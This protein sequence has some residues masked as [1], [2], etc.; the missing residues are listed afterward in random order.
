M[1]NVAD[2]RTFAHSI[3]YIYIYIYKVNS[4]CHIF[5]KNIKIFF[6]PVEKQA[7]TD[8]N[9]SYTARVTL[10]LFILLS[11]N[12]FLCQIRIKIYKNGIIRKNIYKNATQMQHKNL[13]CIYVFYMIRYHKSNGGGESK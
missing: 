8:R 10:F 6:V 2:L 7:K 12:L 5:L 3:I 9:T 13:R 4:F 11:L 1:Y